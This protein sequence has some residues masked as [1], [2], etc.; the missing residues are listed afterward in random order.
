MK[1]CFL[2]PCRIEMEVGKFIK[3]TQAVKVAAQQLPAGT[4]V[5]Q[6]GETVW[7]ANVLPK[8]I[9]LKMLAKEA[10]KYRPTD[11][12]PAPTVSLK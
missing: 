9:L 6:Y 12:Y 1:E 3:L 11:E 2:M 8:R 7:Y 5:F 10:S 4:T